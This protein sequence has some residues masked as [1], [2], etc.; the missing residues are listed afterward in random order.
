MKQLVIPAILTL[1]L[2]AA[3]GAA[4]AAGMAQH[5]SAAKDSLTLTTQQEKTALNDIGKYSSTQNAPSDFRAS[6]GTVVPKTV[7]LRQIPA[8]V[9]DKVPT[10]KPYDFAMFKSRLLIVNP[11]DK[12]IVAVI[13]RRA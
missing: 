8:R 12:K 2:G 3:G 13:N 5:S 9:A 7:S 11:S 1:A 4:A 6:V 10:L